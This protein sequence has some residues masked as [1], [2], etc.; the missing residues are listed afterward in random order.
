MKL[1]YS[2]IQLQYWCLKKLPITFKIAIK[3]RK[4]R[5]KHLLH[6]ESS[7][8]T[9]KIEFY[10]KNPLKRY[11]GC[12]EWSCIYYKIVFFMILGVPA[13]PARLQ[14]LQTCL[15]TITNCHIINSSLPHRRTRPSLPPSRQMGPKPKP[16]T[17]SATAQAPPD[18][19]KRQGSNADQP[20]TKRTRRK[21][22]EA[23]EANDD[24]DDLNKSEDEQE[25]AD[26]VEDEDED[27]VDDPPVSRGGKRGRAVKKGPPRRYVGHDRQRSCPNFFVFFTFF[28]YLP[29]FFRK[30][31]HDRAHDDRERS[32]PRYA[33]HDRNDRALLS[34][35]FLF[36]DYLL[37]FYRKTA[38]DE[39]HD[40]RERS[41]PR[42]A[43]FVDGNDDD[44]WPKRRVS[45]CLGLRWVF[46]YFLCVFF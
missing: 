28:N 12:K 20:K 33:G 19:R 11:Q 21:T 22:N 42:Y 24:D 26:G 27:G 18:S 29:P 32:P 36:F 14:S 46:F 31:A 37:G 41:P 15:Y 23:N 40:D 17:R 3:H 5:K 34:F 39:A 44:N 9:Y 25:A 1:K 7:H 30:S 2:R 38:H 8:K 43:G 10:E 6:A 4:I 16:N 13:C 45:R 35:F